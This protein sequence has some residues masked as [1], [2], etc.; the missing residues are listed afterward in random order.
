MPSS[1]RVAVASTLL[2]ALLVL[3]F[4]VVDASAL[5]GETAVDSSVGTARVND[6]SASLGD[7]IVL[8]VEGDGWLEAAVAD[9]IEKR[10]RERGATVSRRSAVDGPTASA[11]L[12]V[13]VTDAAVAYDPVT[14]AATLSASFAYV[15]S[16]NASLATRMVGGGPTV[17]R[18]QSDAYVVGGDLTIRDRATGVSTWPAYQRRIAGHTA[19][20]VVDGLCGAPGMDRPTF[21]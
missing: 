4:A 13:R 5:R 8:V 17:I 16:G 2:V 14:P 12:L 11:L 7:P 20:A 6:A 1:R 3:G 10:L 19:A 15:Q 9:G 21:Q 18:S